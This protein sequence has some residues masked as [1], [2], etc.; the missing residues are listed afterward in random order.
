MGDLP[1]LSADTLEFDV[2]GAVFGW[3]I[4]AAFALTGLWTALQL[5]RGLGGLSFGLHPPSRASRLLLVVAA[6]LFVPI[7]WLDARLP[8]HGRN[9]KIAVVLIIAQY[10]VAVTALS[11]KRPSA[12]SLLE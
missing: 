3:G 7:G 4:Y 1:G 2:V 10:L 11:L 5:R 6:L 12:S 8:V 9:D